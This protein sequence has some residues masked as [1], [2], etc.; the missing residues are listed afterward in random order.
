MLDPVGNVTQVTD[1]SGNVT[2]FTFDALNR[3]IQQ[4]GGA[5]GKRASLLHTLKDH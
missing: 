1:A 5:L 3:L 4:T 2:K